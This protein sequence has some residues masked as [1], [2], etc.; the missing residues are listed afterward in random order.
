M[1][2]FLK[3]KVACFEISGYHRF[4]QWK[5]W[6]PILIVSM[7]CDWLSL[8]S[9]NFDYVCFHACF[10]IRT[11]NKV[12]T[13]NWN[14][15]SLLLQS[16]GVVF[17]GFDSLRWISKECWSFCGCLVYMVSLNCF[18]EKAWIKS[19]LRGT[20]QVSWAS[21]IFAH[22]TSKW[23]NGI[24]LDPDSRMAKPNPFNLLDPIGTHLNSRSTGLD[25]I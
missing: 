9:V 18:F 21:Q 25:L 19:R 20:T 24:E 11:I 12:S 13:K 22:P 1:I 3:K 23:L 17:Y 8:N 5:N 7:S 14:M 10:F 4:W 15:Y 6:V 16:W 2:F